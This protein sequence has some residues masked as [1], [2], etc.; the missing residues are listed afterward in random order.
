[1]IAKGEMF[2][3]PSMSPAGVLSTRRYS[4]TLVFYF[5]NK[6]GAPRADFAIYCETK[7]DIWR[8]WMLDSIH[9]CFLSDLLQTRTNMTP[10]A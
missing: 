9:P 2:M 5:T 10:Q 6:T 7:L 8:S 4:L 3:K 1:M